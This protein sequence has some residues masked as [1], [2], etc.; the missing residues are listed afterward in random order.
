MI[1]AQ[2]Y[3]LR[4]HGNGTGVLTGS[5]SPSMLSLPIGDKLGL[6]ANL[7]FNLIFGGATCFYAGLNVGLYI[8]QPKPITHCAQTCKA[9]SPARLDRDTGPP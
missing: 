9:A 3:A 8:L 6:D 5:K 7:K 4:F 1:L 2:N